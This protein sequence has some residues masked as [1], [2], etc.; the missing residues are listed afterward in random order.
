M[1]KVPFSKNK[2]STTAKLYELETD[3]KYFNCKSNDSLVLESYSIEIPACTKRLNHFQKLISNKAINRIGFRV[4]IKKVRL[5]EIVGR[6]DE[7][8]G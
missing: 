8:D 4:L 1:E 7:C 5:N 2:D 6:V 3:F